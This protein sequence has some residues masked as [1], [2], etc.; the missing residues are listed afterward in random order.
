[1]KRLLRTLYGEPPLHLTVLL[2]SFVLCGYALARLLA[3]DW[4]AVLQWL[5]GAALVHDLVLVPLYA[6]AD[7]LFHRVVCGR[8]PRS[9]AR[10]A[11]VLHVRVPAFVSLLLLLVH[12]PLISQA[13]GRR[14][15]AATLL[16]P[17]VF[18]GRWLLITA[19][20][21]T[22]SGLLLA[23]RTWRARRRPGSAE[24]LPSA[25]VPVGTGRPARHRS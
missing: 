18:L 6:G 12:W 7:W 1:M 20:L 4:W 21:F 14:Y 11:L 24:V 9:R 5:V 13:A 10:T 3:G 25:D 8:R 22:V 23:L 15:R 2:A 19:V 16:A 17:D